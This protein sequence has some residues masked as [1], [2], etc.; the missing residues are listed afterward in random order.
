MNTFGNKLSFASDYMEGAHPKIMRR[1]AETNILKTA[2]YGMDEFSE[3]A[4][5]KI[6][7]AILR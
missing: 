6:R 2:G 1:L 4:R 3:A 5:N 7:A